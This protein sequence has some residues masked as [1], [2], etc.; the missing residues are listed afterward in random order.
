MEPKIFCQ[1]CTMPIDDPANRGT[2]KDGS[3]SEQYCKY[4]YQ[5]GAFINPGMTLDEMK[6]IVTTQMHKLN[7]PES[8]IQQSLNYLPHLKRWQTAEQT[9]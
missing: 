4:C 5:D 8:L 3:K 7:L 6:K 2:E 1:S 9:A